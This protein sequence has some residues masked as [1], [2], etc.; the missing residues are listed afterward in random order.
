M[1][2]TAAQSAAAEFRPASPLRHKLITVAAHGEKMPRLLRV[3][4]Q[5]LPQPAHVNVNGPFYS[6]N[7]FNSRLSMPNIG[8]FLPNTREA[9]VTILLHELGHLIKGSDKRWLLP[10]DGGNDYL[11]QENTKHV[12]ALCGDQIRHLSRISFARELQ[13]ARTTSSGSAT[14]ANVLKP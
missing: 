14:N 6:G 11:S 9:R 8:G 2:R 4:F 13:V 10:N 12:I 5:L 7:A 3:L 1:S